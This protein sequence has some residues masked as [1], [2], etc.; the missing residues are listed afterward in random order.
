MEAYTLILAVLLVVPPHPTPLV[1]YPGPTVLVAGD[2]RA[3][4]QEG[5]KRA[6]ELQRLLKLTGQSGTVTYICQPVQ[7]M[8]K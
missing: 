7:P 8:T 2:R 5:D 4:S 1:H 6:G 3:C